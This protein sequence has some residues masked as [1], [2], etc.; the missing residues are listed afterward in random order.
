[1]CV[2]SGFSIRLQLLIYPVGEELAG[3]SRPIAYWVHQSSWQK[4]LQGRWRFWSA[5]LE[6]LRSHLAPEYEFHLVITDKWMKICSVETSSLHFIE[7][8]ASILKLDH[9]GSSRQ[10]R[11][12]ARSLILRPVQRP[13]RSH[14]FL[15]SW[16][17][18]LR[19]H[20]AYSEHCK[21]FLPSVSRQ[22]RSPIPLWDQWSQIIDTAGQA[23]FNSHIR[24][25]EFGTCNANCFCMAYK[26][27]GYLL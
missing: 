1:M 12:Y 27:R 20:C 9:D 24:A 10:I 4:S 25:F 5:S 23:P 14:E 15:D 7:R 18:L 11:E 2:S 6:A 3:W 13:H 16:Q 8:V 26:V 19:L 17:C 22:A 21:N